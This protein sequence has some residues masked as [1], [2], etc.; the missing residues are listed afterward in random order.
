MSFLRKL[1]HK[2]RMARLGAPDRAVLREKL[3]Y[4]TPEKLLRLKRAGRETQQL[5]GDVLEFGTALGGS[6]IVLAK[7]RAG[8]RF[9]GFD[10]F[11]MIPEPASDKDDAKSK[12]RYETIRSGGAQGIGGDEYYGYKDNLLDE[13]KAAFARYGVGV[14]G[15]GV[16]LVKGLFQETWPSADVETI[17]LV[18]IDC[19]WYDPVRFC[20]HACADKIVPGG[21]MVIDDYHAYGGCRTAIDEFVAARGDYRFEDGANPFLRRV[22]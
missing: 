3:T 14:D 10:V 12:S 17:S 13:V 4:L 5:P 7:Q 19:D 1:R 15:N 22:H 6:G 16:I 21:I 8:R 18:H 20:L 9:L 11:G 2:I